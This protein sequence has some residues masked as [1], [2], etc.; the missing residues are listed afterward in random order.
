MRV[1]FLE[2]PLRTG[3]GQNDRPHHWGERANRVRQERD[4]VLLAWRRTVGGR[5]AERPRVPCTVLL[6]RLSPGGAAGW[7]GLDEGDNLEG[8]LKA[9][10]DEVARL[11]GLDDADPRVTWRYEQLEGTWGVRVTINSDRTG[12]ELPERPRRAPRKRRQKPRRLLA[13]AQERAGYRA[14]PN[15]V[16]PPRRS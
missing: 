11:L 10:R 3:R 13:R 14:T 4:A 12:E 6:Q 2:I 7:T 9:V 5:G 15:I 8:S 1:W 16:R